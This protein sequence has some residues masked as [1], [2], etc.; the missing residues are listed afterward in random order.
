MNKS[1]LINLVQR[2]D[3]SIKGKDLNLDQRRRLVQKQ[4]AQVHRAAVRK[5]PLGEKRDH[6]LSKL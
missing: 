4:R 6:L 3:G 5:S 1:L 2:K